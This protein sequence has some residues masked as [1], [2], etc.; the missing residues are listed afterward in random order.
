MKH[1]A[2]RLTQSNNIPSFFLE[3]IAEKLLA[4]ICL[5]LLKGKRQFLN[6]V[7]QEFKRF[8]HA[9]LFVYG[10]GP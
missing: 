4:Q 5:Y 1:Q 7:L 6:P 3:H 10:E 2:I 8:L 9:A